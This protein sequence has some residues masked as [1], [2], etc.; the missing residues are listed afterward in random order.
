M[1]VLLLLLLL[2][3]LL[4][5][6]LMLLLPL[7]ATSVRERMD[8]IGYWNWTLLV[9]EVKRLLSKSKVAPSSPALAEKYTHRNTGG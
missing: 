4:V 5:L 9:T 6:V 1:V 7:T 2:V 8:G 3:V